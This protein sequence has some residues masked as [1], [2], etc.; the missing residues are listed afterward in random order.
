MYHN[1]TAIVR[2]FFHAWGTAI[3]P[4]PEVY[5]SR[6][7]GG[8]VSEKSDSVGGFGNPPPFLKM[9]YGGVVRVFFNANTPFLRNFF[10]WYS[11]GLHIQSFALAPNSAT[12]DFVPLARDP[13]RKQG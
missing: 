1:F 6:L 11:F 7:I 4:P 3:P 10:W 9:V 13:P 8:A 2:K 5:I 12:F